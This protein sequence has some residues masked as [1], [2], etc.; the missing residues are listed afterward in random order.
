MS[1]APSRL[2]DFV[3]H[4]KGKKALQHIIDARQKGKIASEEV[5]GTELPGHISAAADA[6]K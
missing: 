3:N 4:F 5:H 2:G 1:I 6:A